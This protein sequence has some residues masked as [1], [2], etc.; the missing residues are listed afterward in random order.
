MVPISPEADYTINT[1][2]GTAPLNVAFTDIS[3]D[4]PTMRNLSFGDGQ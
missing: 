3:T 1:A 4:G 2:S